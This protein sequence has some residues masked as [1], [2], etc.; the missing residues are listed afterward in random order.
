[1]DRR[2]RLRQACSKLMLAL[3]SLAAVLAIV[4]VVSVFVYVAAEGLGAINLDF[5]LRH[6]APVGEPGGGMAN[7]LVGS[8]VI[9][10]GACLVGLPIGLLGGI[11]LAEFGGGQFA[12]WVRFAADVLNG[13]PS[14]VA[15]VFIWAVVVVPMGTPSAIAGS[16]ALSVILIPLVMRTTEEML[17]LV[18]RSQRD[19]SLAVG[20]T[21]TRTTL[22]VVLPAAIAGVVTGILLA[23][24]R[25]MGET[26]PLLFTAL[27]NQ[28]FSLDVRAPMASLPVQIY[29]YAI[30]PFDEWHRQ[31]WAGALVLVAIVLSIS[32]LARV[33]T[34][35]KFRLNT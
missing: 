30:S 34:R 25:I 7:A 18:P 31:A 12:W 13:V 21:R 27:G 32:I 28:W 11:Y 16:L 17:R 26:A 1:M 29:S 35:G 33:V 15:G 22:G 14:I 9:V 23:L 19:A 10:G 6:P 2:R 8:L 3:C 5:F 4:P 24:A 20:A